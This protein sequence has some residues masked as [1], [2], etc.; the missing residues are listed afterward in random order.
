[1]G[2]TMKELARRALPVV[3]LLLASVTP[4]SAECTW[5]LWGQDQVFW[6]YGV[7][8]I[9]PGPT[10]GDAYILTEYPS[11]S[12]CDQARQRQIQTDIAIMKLP[13]T[14]SAGPRSVSHWACVPMPLKPQHIDAATWR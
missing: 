7:L 3:V 6:S 10:R 1:M 9:L 14:K 5:I 12:E 2:Q 8:N 13:E 4:A 11:K